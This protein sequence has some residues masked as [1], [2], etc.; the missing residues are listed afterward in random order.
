MMTLDLH[1]KFFSYDYLIFILILKII[2]NRMLLYAGKFEV[3]TR[4]QKLNK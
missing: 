2:F 3:E 1:K 4:W